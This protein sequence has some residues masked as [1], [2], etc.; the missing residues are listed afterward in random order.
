MVNIKGNVKEEL[1]KIVKENNLTILK[2]ECLG[3]PGYDSQNEGGDGE[4]YIDKA[5]RLN[6]IDDL[7]I[8]YYYDDYDQQVYGTVYCFNSNNGPVWLTRVKHEEFE[9]EHWE[10]NKVPDFYKK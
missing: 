5:P 8:N 10:I 1:L 2:V 6:T 9:R 7:D 4:W 3:Y